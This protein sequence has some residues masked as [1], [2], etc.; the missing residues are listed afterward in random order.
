MLTTATM[1]ESAILNATE[2]FSRT[3]EI[4]DLLV[5]HFDQYGRW[6]GDRRCW[7]RSTFKTARRRMKRALLEPGRRSAFN[8]RGQPIL[9]TSFVL[10]G[11]HPVKLP[12]HEVRG[13]ITIKGNASISAP[14]LTRI[15][16][17]F[18]STST[19]SIDLSALRFV[20]GDLDAIFTWN[21]HIPRLQSVGGSLRQNGS[22]APSLEFVGNRFFI[23][24]SISVCV[25]CLRSVGGHLSA[26]DANY[27]SAPCLKTVKGRLEVDYAVTFRA[28]ELRTVGLSLSAP[29]ATAFFA[30]ALQHVGGDLI[31][32]SA[33]EFHSP[34]MKV[35]GVWYMHSKA[36]RRSP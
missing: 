18:H 21:L 35:G 25:P 33:R 2:H 28:S 24:W 8:R 14:N 19:A 31:T 1:K 27:F 4:Q 6:R 12:W 16:G 17:H 15:K 10:N 9:L 32:F 3:G 22:C 20:G 34:D 29:D 11:D 23:R 26:T 13:S 36:R 30:P 5:P 7:R